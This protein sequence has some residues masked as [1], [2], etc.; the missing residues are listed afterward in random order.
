MQGPAIFRFCLIL[1][2]ACTRDAHRG[3]AFVAVPTEGIAVRAAAR[4]RAADA[5]CQ[6]NVSRLPSGKV[7]LY[8]TILSNIAFAFIITIHHLV[9]GLGR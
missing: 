4:D 6:T 8:V 7:G 1:V 5:T 2:H 9:Y 3:E